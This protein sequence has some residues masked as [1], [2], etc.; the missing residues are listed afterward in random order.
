MRDQAGTDVADIALLPVDLFRAGGDIFLD[1]LQELAEQDLVRLEMDAAAVAEAE[2]DRGS[3]AGRL[4]HQGL[5]LSPGA[6]DLVE[7][8]LLPAVVSVS[9]E[10]PASF[11]VLGGPVELAAVLEDRRQAVQG[12]F[13]LAGF[14]IVGDRLVDLDRVELV[15]ELEPLDAGGEP[16]DRFVVLERVERIG[17]G[18]FGT[19]LGGPAAERRSR[20][21]LGAELAEQETGQLQAG[22][23]E[24]AGV[25][26]DGLGEC[27]PPALA[28]VLGLFKALGNPVIDRRAVRLDGCAPACWPPQ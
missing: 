13:V 15:G 20:D 3:P 21:R 23:V 5:E 4:G 6:E 12:L 14:G 7:L 19:A 27:P 1:V 24:Q 17:A 18:C 8:L 9:V 26:F 11:Q 2:V 10:H 22:R 28:V 16:G 25:G